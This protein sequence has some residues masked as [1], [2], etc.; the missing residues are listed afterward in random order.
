MIDIVYLDNIY[1]I[2]FLFRRERLRRKYKRRV[3]VTL[4][5][6]AYCLPKSD[7]T[8][9]HH[10]IGNF[11]EAGHVGALHVVD[12]AVGACAILHA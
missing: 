1:I 2:A 12:V 4:R 7:H 3:I 8:L 11:D 5:L 9:S 6:F 10:G